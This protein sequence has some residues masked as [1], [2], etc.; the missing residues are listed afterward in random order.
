[1]CVFTKY[2]ICYICIWIKNSYETQNFFWHQQHC[3]CIVDVPHLC[4]VDIR[5]TSYVYMH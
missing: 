1:V 2:E 4:I 3:L 5:G